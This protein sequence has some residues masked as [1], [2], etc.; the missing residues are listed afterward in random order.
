[1]DVAVCTSMAFFRRICRKAFE[2]MLPKAF[3][4]KN[5]EKIIGANPEKRFALSAS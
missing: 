1:M 3:H 4:N 2:A 5:A